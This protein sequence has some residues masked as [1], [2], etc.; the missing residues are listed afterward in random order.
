M[1]RITER[2]A[3]NMKNRRLKIYII[4]IMVLPRKVTSELH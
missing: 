2:P 1:E 4:I 3:R